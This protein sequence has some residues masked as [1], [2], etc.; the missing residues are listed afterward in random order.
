[1]HFIIDLDLDL[2]LDA[3]PIAGYIAI[4]R[5]VRRP[6]HSRLELSSA[7]EESRAT[8]AR[9]A[10]APERSTTPDRYAPRSGTL[11]DDGCTDTQHL[12]VA[13]WLGRRTR[14]TWMLLGAWTC[15]GWSAI[16][17]PALAATDDARVPRAVG[18]RRSSECSLLS[19][20]RRPR[21]TMR[22]PVR[23]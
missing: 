1:M 18:P 8:P 15:A 7:I 2:D 19:A 16:A 20:M 22:A 3:T 13:T 23:R 14:P 4:E 12:G 9:T 11:T 10:A 6:F 17:V 21:R 5:R